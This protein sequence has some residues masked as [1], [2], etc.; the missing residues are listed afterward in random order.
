MNDDQGQMI[1]QGELHSGIGMI[2]L[3]QP[4]A[5]EDLEIIFS[6][7]SSSSYLVNFLASQSW[8]SL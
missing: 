6:G 7:D 8:I 2:K 4:A 1:G 5:E 3:K